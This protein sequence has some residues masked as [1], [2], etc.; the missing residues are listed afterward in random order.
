MFSRRKAFSALAASSSLIVV[1]KVREHHFV[2]HCCL[3][4]HQFEASV[5][6]SIV[7]FLNK[8]TYYNFFKPPFI[9]FSNSIIVDGLKD[10]T[11]LILWFD[12][13]AENSVSIIFKHFIYTIFGET[14]IFALFFHVCQK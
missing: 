1:Y 11:G 8:H 10:S 3:N 6:L 2:L 14:L 13:Y 9:S 4:V 7:L 5:S 12:R